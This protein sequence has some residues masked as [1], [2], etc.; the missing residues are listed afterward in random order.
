MSS[1]PA[2]FH[3]N[4][5]SKAKTITPIAEHP[6]PFPAL[7]IAFAGLQAARQLCGSQ[8]HAAP[9]APHSRQVAV[10]SFGQPPPRPPREDSNFSESPDTASLEGMPPQLQSISLDPDLMEC[11]LP[12]LLLD[13][14]T[15][16]APLVSPVCPAL[17]S[18]KH[19]GGTPI[20]RTCALELGSP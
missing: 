16:P 6:L 19:L 18:H 12:R 1:S 20:P 17:V 13:R 15:A 4:Q 9:G 11:A 2:S 10:A 7:Q 14:S 3:P 8:G 5:Q